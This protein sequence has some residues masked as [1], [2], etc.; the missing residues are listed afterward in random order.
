MPGGIQQ[1]PGRERLSAGISRAGPSTGPRCF[2]H[3]KGGHRPPF[4]TS[5]RAYFMR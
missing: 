3:E 5:Y 1:L 4:S 2:G